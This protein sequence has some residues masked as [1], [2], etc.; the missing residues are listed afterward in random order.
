MPLVSS[1]CHPPPIRTHATALP[2]APF[3]THVPTCLSG[4]ALRHRRVV[5]KLGDFATARA[6]DLSN[7]V[8]STAGNRLTLAPEVEDFGWV[9]MASLLPWF[10]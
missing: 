4:R 7:P 3:F 10:A 2:A 5:V 9:C 6:L 1:S 8:A